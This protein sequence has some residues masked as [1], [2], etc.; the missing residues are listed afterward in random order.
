[1]VPGLSKGVRTKGLGVV[2]RGLAC[3]EV[4]INYYIDE[5]EIASWHGGGSLRWLI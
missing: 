5:V 4:V 3:V 2:N 1:M